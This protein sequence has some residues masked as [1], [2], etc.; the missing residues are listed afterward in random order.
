MTIAYTDGACSGNPGPGGWAW[1]V[2]DG[3]YASGFEAHSTNQRMEIK[4]AYEAAIA[5]PGPLEIVSD[6]TYV[7]HCFK[8]RWWEGC[9]RRGWRSAKGTAV[10]N[11]DLWVPLVALVIDDRPGEVRFRWV[12]GHS[13]DTMNNFVDSLAKGAARSGVGRSQRH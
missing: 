1:A 10:A 11:Q 8:D 3:P 9:R 6:S 4:A 2:P 12:K 7:V 5:L 13:T